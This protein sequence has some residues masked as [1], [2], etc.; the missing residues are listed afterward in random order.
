MRKKVASTS[1]LKG[2][3]QQSNSN[4][5]Y[6]KILKLHKE[7]SP[8]VSFIMEDGSKTVLHITKEFLATERN[9]RKSAGDIKN[10]LFALQH[11]YGAVSFSL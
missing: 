1:K 6:N 5:L 3:V 8:T 4:S 11:D 2:G 9:G 10:D 7:A